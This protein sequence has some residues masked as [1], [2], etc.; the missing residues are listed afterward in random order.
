M[1]HWANY[2]RLTSAAS[3]VSLPA[4]TRLRSIV[5]GTGSAGATV[6]LTNGTTINCASPGSYWFGDARF[7]SA[8]TATLN[9]GG[10][11]D[12]SIIYI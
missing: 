10:T 4:N 12:V 8:L 11:T 6:T 3:T 9:S 5:V 7:P 2:A 1:S